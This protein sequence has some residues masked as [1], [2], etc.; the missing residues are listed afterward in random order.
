MT[1]VDLFIP[2]F[3]RPDFLERILSYYDTNKVDFNI[4]IADSSSMPNKVKNRKIISSFPGLKILYLDKFSDKLISHLKFAEMLKYGKSKYSVFCADDDFIVP[5]GIKEAVAFLEKNS[6]YSSAQGSYISFYMYE[7]PFGLKKFWWKFIYPYHSVTSSNPKERL[8]SHFTGPFQVL[9]S[10]R[11]TDVVKLAYGEFLKSR[12]DPLLFGELLPGLLTLIYGKMKHLN[13][14]F[15]ARQ[16]F[17]TSYG[18]W[19]SLRDAKETG[20]FETE[21]VKFKDCLVANLVKFKIPKKQASEI[22]D[23]NMKIYIEASAQEHILGR[24]NLVLKYFPKFVA[25]GLRLI[26]AKYLFSKEKK[27]RIGLID[28][29]KSKHFKDYELIRQT[30][31]R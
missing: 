17:S 2:T 27:D 19:P 28:R 7:K 1:P 16:A 21:Y 9:W 8:I 24:I 31:L 20:R 6:D 26:H 29:P 4:I 12:V 15:G 30:V 10:V 5:N 3:N 25:K 18:Y 11:R 23:S 14:F 13:T 22:I